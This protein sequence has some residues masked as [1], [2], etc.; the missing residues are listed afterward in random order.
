MLFRRRRR[1]IVCRNAVELM[2][3]YLEGALSARETARLEAHLVD[4]PHCTEHLAQLR[5]TIATIGRIE[6]E[7]L[8]P[9][10][11]EDLVGLYRR[12]QHG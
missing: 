4:C 1:A 3:D 9:E 12:W 5:A 6:P 11:V 7:D 2:T 8:P 10:A